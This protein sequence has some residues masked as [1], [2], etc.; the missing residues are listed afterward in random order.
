[1]TS[2]GLL[3]SL[4]GLIGILYVFIV[5]ALSG[6]SVPGWAGLIALL[7]LIG[8]L[9]SLH[10][11]VIGA[12]LSRVLSESRGRPIY[13]VAAETS[14]VDSSA[15]IPSKVEKFPTHNAVIWITGLS[16]SGKTTLAHAVLR[17][18]KANGVHAVHI[19]GD[20]MRQTIALLDLEFGYQPD[21]RKRLGLFY[22]KMASLLA[23]QGNVV[24]V[25]TISM[26]NEVFRLNRLSNH[27]YLEVFLD[28]SPTLRQR[29]IKQRLEMQDVGTDSI[30]IPN[31]PEVDFP[32]NSDFV[33]T[34]S[35]QTKT[36]IDEM[37]QQICMRVSV[38]IQK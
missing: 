5:R 30:P 19:D 31:D 25:S 16:G 29:R 37:A 23:L 3:S 1:M 4:T 7:L 2:L 21:D 18:L 33:F 28:V 15:R 20:N 11:G 8:S 10:L 22:S 35:D 17:L 13:F 9:L 32:V 24:V 12:Y 27:T 14:G 6:I 26:Y 36:T 38:M 34:D